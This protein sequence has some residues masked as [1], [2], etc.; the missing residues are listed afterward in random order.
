VSAL[1]EGITKARQ[2]DPTVQ[3]RVEQPA[4]SA[5]KDM[6]EVKRTLGEGVKV[7][8]CAWGERKSLKPYRLWL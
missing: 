8:G 1:L 2:A 4:S 5:L 7:F 3:Y 6:P